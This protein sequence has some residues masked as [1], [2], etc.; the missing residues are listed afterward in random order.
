LRDHV[1]AG[2]VGFDDLVV[3][4]INGVEEIIDVGD[5]EPVEPKVAQVRD[6]VEPYVGF[7]ASD[8]LRRPGLA[9]GVEPLRFRQLP[10]KGQRGVL[11]VLVRG[12]AD[13][14]AAQD[15]LARVSLR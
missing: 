8:R 7:V 2:G 14:G 4:L 6:Q 5:R 9:F 11:L 10:R 1:P 12:P 3:Q 15:R 13:E